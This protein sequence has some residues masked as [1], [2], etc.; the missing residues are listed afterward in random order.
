MRSVRGASAPLFNA[1]P[2]EE[3]GDKG[4]E[5]DRQSLA[6]YFIKEKLLQ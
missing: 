4:G 1:L 2:F 3:K 6:P 5:V